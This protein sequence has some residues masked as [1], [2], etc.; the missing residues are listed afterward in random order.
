MTTTT[1]SAGTSFAP[2]ADKARNAG[3]T[4]FA[5]LF[6]RLV[7]GQEVRAR[8]IVRSHLAHQP[9]EALARLGWT[10]DEI[11]A[12]RRDGHVGAAYPL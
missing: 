7:A 4:L 9:D 10:P 3:P 8:R 12:L 2:T 5:R 6:A 11:A 1:L